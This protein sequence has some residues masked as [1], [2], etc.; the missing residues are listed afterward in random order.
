MWFIFMTWK[1]WFHLFVFTIVRLFTPKKSTSQKVYFVTLIHSAIL[2]D[3]LY[4]T[5]PCNSFDAVWSPLRTEDTKSSR[6]EK[7]H[8][9]VRDPKPGAE[10]YQQV[11]AGLGILWPP[12]KVGPITP[13]PPPSPI[14]NC[15]CVSFV[16]QSVTPKLYNK[17]YEAFFWSLA[18]RKAK[19]LKDTIQFIFVVTLVQFFPYYF[20]FDLPFQWELC[21]VRS[22]FFVLEIFL[23]KNG[24]L[25][26]KCESLISSP[27]RQQIYPYF[28]P[29]FR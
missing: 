11:S 27:S 25:L 8:F 23:F 21:V 15:L 14:W 7:Y 9:P 20:P 29:V 28:F 4:L 16:N 5:L 12:K 3:L 1:L 18:W 13:I 26:I 22:P 2:R 6:T 19:K 24:R 10:F 17:W